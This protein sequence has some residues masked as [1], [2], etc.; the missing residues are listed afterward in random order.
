MMIDMDELEIMNHIKD[1]TPGSMTVFVDFPFYMERHLRCLPY[2]RYDYSRFISDDGSRLSLRGYGMARSA[3][4]DMTRI[5]LFFLLYEEKLRQFYVE[6]N[7]A[8]KVA[9]EELEAATHRTRSETDWR[10]HA[11]LIRAQ[12]EVRKKVDS[13][14]RDMYREWFGKCSPVLSEKEI[15]NLK[16]LSAKSLNI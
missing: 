16:K 13:L 14:F 6:Y 2:T 9:D 7:K 12:F 11:P 15:D 10:K 8:K 1:L 4:E 5:G 3:I